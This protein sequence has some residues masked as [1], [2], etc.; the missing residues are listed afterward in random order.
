MQETETKIK[1]TILGDIKVASHR[2]EKY[3][4]YEISRQQKKREL[5]KIAPLVPRT[6]KLVFMEAV[7]V[8]IFE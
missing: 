8:M 7:K 3:N 1:K 6:P 5:E 2:N 4:R